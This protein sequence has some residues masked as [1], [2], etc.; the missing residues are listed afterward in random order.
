MDAAPA[1]PPPPIATG[2]ME[3]SSNVTVQFELSR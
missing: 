1:A 2:E 3:L